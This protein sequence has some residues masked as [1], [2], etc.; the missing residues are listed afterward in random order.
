MISAPTNPAGH[1]V[2]ERTML[3]GPPK[4][5][6]SHQYLNIAKWHQ[7][8][9]SDAKF[10]VLSSDTSYEVLLMNEE[11]CDL[12]NVDYVD[13]VTFQDWID[14][15]RK[16]N[17]KMRGHDWLC[18]DLMDHAWGAVQDEYARALAK[19]SGKDLEDIGDLWATTGA[20]DST[21]PISGWEWGM[22]NGR[23][24]VLANNYLLRCPGHL[25]VIAGVKELTKDSGS[26]SSGEKPKT[27]EMFG[28][29]GVKPS[30]QKE[31]PWR[32]H[33]IIYVD[34][35]GDKR[36]KMATAGERFGRRRRLGK[37]LSN[38]LVR[39]EPIE[40]FFLNYYVE[41]GQWTV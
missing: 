29:L 17:A 6:K 5:G 36:Q 11:F 2:R 37:V 38:G 10:Y 1:V 18:A 33:S 22:P 34:S 7:Q 20:S 13:V 16:F 4:V 30:G 35:D 9:G 31:D 40:D 27:K 41:I 19:Q 39:P 28:H 25:M 21:Y 3:F 26:G 15:A 14:G 24:R 23:Y 12:E 8:M 32:Y